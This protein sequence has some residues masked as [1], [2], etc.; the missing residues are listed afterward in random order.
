MPDTDPEVAEIVCGWPKA[1]A[2]TVVLFS[3]A[4]TLLGAS[5]ASSQVFFRDQFDSPASLAQYTVIGEQFISFFPPPLHTVEA[6]NGQLKIQTAAVFPNG[7]GNPPVLLG[8]ALLMGQNTTFGSGFSSTLS[9]NSGL[10]SWAFNVAN[11]DGSFN[12]GFDFVLAST[13]LNP[14]TAG[15]KG[16]SLAGGGLVGNRMMV[17]RFDSGLNIGSAIIIDLTNGLAPLPQAGSFRITFN[18]TNSE[19]KLLGTYGTSFQEP[20]GV[21][22]LL[23]TGFDA[24]YASQDLPFWGFGGHTTGTDVFDNVTVSIIPEPGSAEFLL[25][26][27]LMMFAVAFRWQSLGQRRPKR[28]SER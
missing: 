9:S 16:Y 7:S 24:L 18:P 2:R 27:T 6:T 15:A 19:W 11:Q 28:P 26:G 8:S 22:E 23:G 25:A 5:T 10:V 4:L 1:R 14:R 12:N 20:T 13:H 3:V 21:T 17:R